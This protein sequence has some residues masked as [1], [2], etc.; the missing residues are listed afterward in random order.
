WQ[1]RELIAILGDRLDQKRRT[2]LAIAFSPDG[3]FL[4]AGSEDNIVRLYDTAQLMWPARLVEHVHRVPCVAFAPD[5]QWL[6]SGAGD[7]SIILWD[8]KGQSQKRLD[9]HGDGTTALA[10]AP[11]GTTLASAG[12]DGRIKLWR[13]PVHGNSLR[14][15]EV[16]NTR[17]L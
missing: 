5:G 8:T 12:G 16:N 15:I 10:F 11:D 1:P 2:P 6:T 3:R 9:G 13:D 17:P 7:G 4:A 14:I